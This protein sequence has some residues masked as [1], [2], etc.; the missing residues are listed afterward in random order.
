MFF[1]KGSQTN[2]NSGLLKSKLNYGLPSLE[3]YLGS[4][5]KSSYAVIQTSYRTVRNEL[6]QKSKVDNRE[7]DS[8]LEIQ[9][10]WNKVEK[11]R[12]WNFEKKPTWNFFESGISLGF[13]YLS[14]IHIV[15]NII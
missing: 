15:M 10:D 11:G 7:V 6:F 14:V 1:S 5:L 2:C 4:L 12:E 3:G 9:R 13:L 8:M